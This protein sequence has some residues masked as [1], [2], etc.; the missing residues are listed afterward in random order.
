MNDFVQLIEKQLSIPD[1]IIV[2][3]NN[4]TIS[5]FLDMLCSRMDS[6]V[7]ECDIFHQPEHWK[8]PKTKQ[9]RNV[10][11]MSVS[12]RNHFRHRWPQQMDRRRR[13]CELWNIA[14]L[15]NVICTFPVNSYCLQPNLHVRLG[16]FHLDRSAT[17]RH[18]TA[19]L[20]SPNKANFSSR[21]LKGKI[22]IR[23]VTWIPDAARPSD[24]S[25][26]WV[27]IL[28]LDAISVDWLE[29]SLVNI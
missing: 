9:I 1:R 15:Q 5:T 20:W 26:T 19:L 25:K 12:F 17:S 7:Q 29:F 14:R 24:V 27:E 3:A 11:S 10:I 22:K 6:K 18:W 8:S 28:V 13:R 16:S 21:S 23:N 2:S 4:F